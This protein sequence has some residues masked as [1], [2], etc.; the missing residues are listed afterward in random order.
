VPTR[1]D[2][3]E[4]RRS[5]PRRSGVAETTPAAGRRATR[6][7]VT[8]RRRGVGLPAQRRARS[9]RTKRT[10]VLA[11]I[12]PD[13]AKRILRPIAREVELRHSPAVSPWLVGNTMDDP[14]RSTL[15]AQSFLE[16][17]VDGVLF[18]SSGPMWRLSICSRP[19]RSRDHTPRM[20]RSNVPRTGD[21]RRG[22]FSRRGTDGHGH[23]KIEAWLVP[24]RSETP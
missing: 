15:Y 9:L 1:Q 7:R 16:R 20:F 12:L 5:V 2:G 8:G 3:A 13:I 6:A 10:R 17:Q 24:P 19:P 22:G 21:N 4:T 23:R 14:A 18:V 11:L